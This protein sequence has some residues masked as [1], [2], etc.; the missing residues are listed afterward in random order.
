MSPVGPQ[1]NV[2]GARCDVCKPGFYN[3]QGSRPQGCSDCFC[4]GVSDVCESSSWSTAQ[5][6]DAPAQ[7][8]LHLRSRPDPLRPVQVL[9]A[10]AWLLP[11]PAPPRAPA[12]RDP[13]P[14]TP[15]NASS[16]HAQLLLWE[17]PE[18]FLGN[19][20]RLLSVEQDACGP[21]A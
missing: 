4:F 21:P 10:D 19:K 17:A 11:P 6:C 9:H 5:V 1:V 12:V 20:V 7:P 8:Q 14:H 2:M 18:R 13:D 15:A 16:G 3:L